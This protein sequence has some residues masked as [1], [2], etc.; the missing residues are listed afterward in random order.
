MR[1]NSPFK[2]FRSCT[3]CYESNEGYPPPGAIRHPKHGCY[4]GMGCNECK[5]RGFVRDHAADYFTS[6]STEEI[7]VEMREKND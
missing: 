1:A 7:I 5:G 3:G 4:L 2:H 6:L